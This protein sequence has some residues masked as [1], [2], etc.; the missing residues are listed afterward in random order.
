MK[1]A[2]KRFRCYDNGVVYP[3]TFDYNG[4]GGIFQMTLIELS[5]FISVL[6]FIL[7]LLHRDN[8]QLQEA[9]V[10]SITTISEPCDVV[11]LR[12]KVF[13][14]CGVLIIFYDGQLITVDNAKYD[15]RLELLE[16]P[17]EAVLTITTD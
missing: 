8:L 9:G 4:D 13:V 16:E 14:K 5:G 1:G 6:A 12:V 11:D 15:R 17:V 7:W 2:Q 10:L 3:C